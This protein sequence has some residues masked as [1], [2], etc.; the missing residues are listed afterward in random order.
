MRRAFLLISLPALLFLSAAHV[1]QAKGRYDRGKALFRRHCA[2]CLSM[3]WAWSPTPPRPDRPVDLRR[4]AAAL[5]PYKVCTYQHR[6]TRAG[7]KGPACYPGRIPRRDRLDILYYLHRRAQGGL[8]PPRPVALR[9]PSYRGGA[10]RRTLAAR[11]R[12]ALTRYKNL[13]LLRRIQSRRRL[14]PW[15]RPAAARA[16][17]RATPRE[18]GR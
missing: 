7:I 1:A 16:S 12:T 6:Q 5:P 9:P 18:R 4:L 8:V 3:G 17:R 14:L 11:R 2:S 15:R 10:L 13:I